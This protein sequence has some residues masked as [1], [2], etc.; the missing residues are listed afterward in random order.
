MNE[1]I[2]TGKSWEEGHRW[3]LSDRALHYGDG[4]FETVR[5]NAS[6][7]APLWRL[8]RQRVL[9]GLIA[10]EFPMDSLDKL[11]HAWEQLP[12]HTKK[13]GG[14]LLISRG[15]AP[16]GYGYPLDAHI[17]MLWQPFEAPD[18]AIN[19]V[20]NGFACEFSKVILSEQPLLAGVKHLNRLD[21]I[22]ARSH[23]PEYCHEVV[24][25]NAAGDVIEGCMSNIFLFQQGK[26][27][28]PHI[29]TCG[30]NGVIRRWLINSEDVS[31][32]KVTTAQLFEAEAVFFCNTLNGIIPVRELAGHAYSSES[33][34]WERAL[35]LQKNLEYLFC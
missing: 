18:W 7:K 12:E 2:W 26:L 4:L 24:M 15:S 13:S 28:T 10:L 5:F 27:I 32:E 11:D 23:F 33:Y 21:Q 25:C 20:P 35:E 9:Q 31:V 29:T 6:G 14:K 3:S 17:V 19:R 30:V 16:R 8:H 22:L 1:L 34:G